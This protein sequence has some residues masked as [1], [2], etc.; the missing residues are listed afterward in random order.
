MV[1]FLSI[2][3]RIPVEYITRRSAILAKV[4]SGKTYNA[5]VIE[6]EFARKGMPF[7]VID[8]MGAHWGIR[9]KYPI[10]IMGGSHGDLELTPDDGRYIAQLVVD[11]NISVIC[12]I[13]EFKKEDQQKFAADFGDELF[14]LHK[15]SSTP[16][17][18]FWEEADIF[19]PQKSQVVSLPVLDTLVRRGRQFGIGS[20]MITQR[21]AVLNKDV[22]T[23][24]DIYFFMNMIA[25]QDIKVVEELLQA[26]NTSKKERQ[27]YIQQMMTFAKGQSLMFSPS[28]LGK[29]KIFQGRKKHTYHAGQT[30]AYGVIQK[31][32]PMLNYDIAHIKKALNKLA[33]NEEEDEA[34]SAET[35]N[36][37]KPYIYAATGIIGVILVFA[38]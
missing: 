21:P 10:L 22:L 31:I 34:I 2:G 23:Q 15:K 25:K 6:E 12:D 8:P 16:R 4:D 7:V 3:M 33:G 19:A 17:H 20:T 30:P 35:L 13:N 26:S 29:I 38:L 27:T 5:G 36:N 24:V 9:S 28:W 18:V 14:L 32:P 1:S 37:L 11:Q